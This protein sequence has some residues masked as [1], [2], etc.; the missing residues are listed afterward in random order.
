LIEARPDLA[1]AVGVLADGQG[2]VLISR[3]PG[4]GHAG[5]WWEFPGGKIQ[6]GETPVQ[7]L[8]RELD[9]ELGIAVTGARPLIDYRYAYPDRTVVLHVFEVERYTGC[10][11]GR[12]GQ[13][14]RWVARD[15]L[16]GAGLLPADQPIIA[17]IS[18]R[19][20]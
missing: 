16:P 5:G 15:E 12:E 7:G 6:P 14:L 8:V 20:A 18:T 17:A 3:R 11:A 2:R 19:S 9:E 4:S 10:P 1:V 13:P